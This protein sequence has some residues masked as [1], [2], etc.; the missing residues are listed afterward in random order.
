VEVGM[1]DVIPHTSIK[2]QLSKGLSYLIKSSDFETC[3]A[4]HNDGDVYLDVHFSHHSAYWKEDR[5]GLATEGRYHLVWC[6]YYDSVLVPWQSG[7]WK[8]KN[9]PIVVIC[10][11]IAA[12]L[13]VINSAQVDRNVIR[14]VL[15]QEVDKLADQGLFTHFWRLRLNLLL[16]T[17]QIEC[18]SSKGAAFTHGPDSRTIISLDDKR[19]R[20]ENE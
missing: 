14:R 13:D 4:G 1:P 18:I 19:L 9:N 20:P 5:D 6:S 2:Y 8:D 11:S 17:K 7:P 3:F 10:E 15:L 16:K 12:P